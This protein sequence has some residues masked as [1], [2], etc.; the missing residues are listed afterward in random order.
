MVVMLSFDLDTKPSFRSEDVGFMRA[1]K[2]IKGKLE[3][4]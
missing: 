3:I 1:L 4:K 2:A